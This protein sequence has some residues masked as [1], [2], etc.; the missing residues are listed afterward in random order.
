MNKTAYI[1][2]S[3]LIALTALSGFLLSAPYA[4][5][6]NSGTITLNLDVPADCSLTINQ[7]THSTT[8]NSGSDAPIGA[9]TIKSICNDPGGLAVYAT[10]YTNDSYGNNNLTASI[11]GSTYNIP[12]ATDQAP[13]SQ[14]NMTL[15]AVSGNYAPAIVT[16]YDSAHAIP[17]EYTKVAYR[18]SMTD[19]G[20]GATGANFTATFN[21]HVALDQPAGTYTGKVKFLLVHPN[22]NNAA[23]ETLRTLQDVDSWGTSVALGEEV[24]AIDIRD[25]QMYKVKR[26]KM[27][28]AGTETMLWMSNL[29]L[30]AEEFSVALDSS[31]TNLASGVSAIPAATFMAW[32][33][34][35]SGTSLSY[36]D[37]K[38]TPITASNASNGQAADIYGNQYGTLYNYAA[39]S[40]GTYTYEGGSGTGNA[41]SDLCPAGWR[42]P[43]G[44]NSGE[45][46]AL[47]DSYSI[48]GNINSQAAQNAITL[49]SNLGFSMAGNSQNTPG[50]QGEVAN[51]WSSTFGDSYDMH[52][53]GF[54]SSFMASNTRNL[55]HNVFSVRCIAQ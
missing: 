20:S 16:G 24:E 2:P 7:T 36:T 45:F 54:T 33:V 17:E 25:G 32:D 51:Y 26:L 42:M 4:S 22:I 34:T 44:G 35:I 8:V 43:T 46:K 52:N 53:F 28:A 12:S 50:G 18:N 39:A 10:G 30:G 49:Q 29:N 14:W 9:S 48:F 55:R 1:V 27:N 21:I 13:G 11:N 47:T 40:A 5:A 37:P 23:P 6:D 41:T 31:N 38:F 19:G 15:T 3:A